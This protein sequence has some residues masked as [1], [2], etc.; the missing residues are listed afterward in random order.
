MAQSMESLCRICAGSDSE[1]KSLLCVFSTSIEYEPQSIEPT[2]DGQNKRSTGTLAQT[3]AEAMAACLDV[4]IKPNDQ[5][6]QRICYK[7]LEKLRLSWELRETCKSSEEQLKRML[8]DSV[9]EMPLMKREESIQSSLD[10]EEFLVESDVVFAD[11]EV[12]EEYELILEKDKTK[13]SNPNDPLHTENG[14]LLSDLSKEHYDIKK[15]DDTY[16]DLV[17][18]EDYRCCGCFQYFCSRSAMEEHCKREHHSEVSSR[19]DRTSRYECS[20]CRKLFASSDALSFHQ[21]MARSR[22][23][24]HCKQCQMLLPSK[25]QL[26]VHLKSHTELKI[27]MLSQPTA[28][29]SISNHQYEVPVK[30]LPSN[31][32]SEP[33]LASKCRLVKH[34]ITF[35][36]MAFDG[37]CCCECWFY[38][39][40]KREM[41]RHGEKEHYNN[42]G[43]EEEM[44]CFACLRSF[45]TKTSF[46]EH[47][48][49]LNAK[50]IYYCRPCKQMFRSSDKL[51]EHQNVSEN[52]EGFIELE[53][54][55]IKE[56]VEIEENATDT[57][58]SDQPTVE[59]SRRTRTGRKVINESLTVDGDGDAQ[60]VAD[61]DNGDVDYEPDVNS[62]SRRCDESYGRRLHAPKIKRNDPEIAE[63]TVVDISGQDTI[64]CCGCYKTFITEEEALE[65]RSEQH[66]QHKLPESKEKPYECERCYRRFVKAVSLQV[67]RQFVKTVQVYA[68]KL[69]SEKFTFQTPF[70]LHYIQ[71]EN[72]S[73]K[74]KDDKRG[75]KPRITENDSKYFCCF[76]FC[77]QSYTEYSELLSHV[78]E[79]HGVKRNQFKDYRDTDQNCCE[80]CFRSFTNYRALLRHVS[81]GKKAKSA[82]R[83][84]C[85]SCGMQFKSLALLKDHENKHLGIKPYECEV[86]NKS[87]GSKNILTNH[88]IVHQASRPFS[89]EICG[90]TFARKRNY[91]DHSMTHMNE[92]PWECEICKLTFR[93]ES[94][95][96]THKRRHTGV[97]PYKC[98]FCE[99][100][101]SHATDRKRHEMAAHTGE[102]PHQ[103]SFCPFAFIRK[104]QLVIHERTHTGEKPFECQYCGQAFIQQSYLTR[105]MASHKQRDDAV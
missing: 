66:Q 88:M 21:Q 59:T 91:K 13:H 68:C 96:L 27:E 37:F 40:T 39:K 62:R 103:C 42:R 95:F 53:M 29:Q 65:H 45:D 7:C 25:R 52:H 67:H 28:F 38:C 10:E 33:P 75:A 9:A 60:T 19:G 16:W 73:W 71:H 69:C 17:E 56:E 20:V 86:C 48:E 102:K 24:F 99:K 82:N 74:W 89:C 90:K 51:Q 54:I 87:F 5:L 6:P 47:M 57:K 85:S 30:S 31:K 104:R 3:V 94:Q 101:F 78:D 41:S 4:D 58:S 100:V 8:Q 61:C 84:T 77:T 22:Q 35:D 98:K 1:R 64:R 97:R 92:K 26:K 18:V 49:Q 36:Y 93:I 50:Q 81:Q 80:I 34:F 44:V 79:N 15:G 72:Q 76:N 63:I 12:L 55:D 11:E 32:Q 83:H 23:L 105:H 14:W 70:L 2:D 43:F 46:E